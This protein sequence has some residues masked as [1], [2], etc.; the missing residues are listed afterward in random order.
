MS[1]YPAVAVHGLAKRFGDTVA[2]AGFDLEI[3]VGSLF[4]I[5]GPNGAGKTTA[6]SMLT[7]VLRPDGGTASVFGHDVWSDPAA[8]KAL[9]GVLPDGPATFDRLSGAE[10]VEY[11]GRLYGLGRDDA[12]QRARQLLRVLG[13]SASA[14]VLVADYSAGMRKK[15]GLACA[16]V[17]APR[18]LVLDE[19]FEAVDPVSAETVRGLLRRFAG[20]GGTV[21]M[22]SHVMELVEAICDRVAIVD[23]GRVLVTGTLAQVRG[24][25][26]SLQRRFLDLVAGGS[27]GE[28]DLPWLR[29]SSR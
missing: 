22:S 16:L 6:L 4:G 24:D 28:D 8:A 20:D 15:V 23:A 11:S 9:I 25:A 13:L 19:P 12:R 17:H 1:T 18:L 26:A 10:L 27:A 3:P 7:G 14:P 21:V 2:V 29:C 5:V